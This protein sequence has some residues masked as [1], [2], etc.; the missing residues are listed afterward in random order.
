[1]LHNIKELT[2]FSVGATDG[3]IGKVKDAYF[4]DQRWAIRHLVV[5]TGG[6]L[7]ER[8]VLVSPRSVRGID[9]NDEVIRVD[10][11]KDQVKDSPSIDTDRPVSRQHEIDY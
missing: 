1:M 3:E 2:G 10:L 7:S 8:K 9:W 11:T 5:D 4:D 6:W